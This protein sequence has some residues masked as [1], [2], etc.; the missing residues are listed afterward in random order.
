MMAH[1]EVMSLEDIV[2]DDNF[3]MVIPLTRRN[4]KQH[5]DGEESS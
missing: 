1:F 5:E 4:K 2:I 3:N